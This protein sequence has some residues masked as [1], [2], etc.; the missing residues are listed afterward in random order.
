VDY[1]SEALRVGVKTPGWQQ[2]VQ[3]IELA[4]KPKFVQ[5]FC[6]TLDWWFIAIF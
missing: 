1:I 3:I 2:Q 6:A 5:S 4:I